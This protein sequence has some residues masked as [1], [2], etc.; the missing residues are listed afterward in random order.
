MQQPQDPAE[1][2]QVRELF[3]QAFDLPENDRQRYLDEVCG[4]NLDLLQKVKALLDQAGPA[5]KKLDEIAE[6]LIWPSLKSFKDTP[7][8]LDDWLGTGLDPN[9]NDSLTGKTISH[10]K[11][12]E[13]VGR[14]GMGVVYKAHDHM[15]ER[16]VALKFLPPAMGADSNAKERFIREAKVACEIDHPNIATVHEIGETEDGQMF[17]AMGYYQGESLKQRIDQGSINTKESI[18]LVRQLAA[19]LS[20]IHENKIIH[21]DIKPGN[22]IVT[23]DGTMK[24]LDF[25]LAKLSFESGYTQVGQ[26]IGTVAYMS[27]EQARAE[28]IDERTDI[29][30][31]GVVF[32]EMLTG[33][34]PFDGSDAPSTMHAILEKDPQLPPEFN[35]SIPRPV[36]EI[37]GLCL[38]K[39]PD[40]RYQSA[41]DLISDLDRVIEGERLPHR[42]G[43]K[44]WA[45]HSRKRKILIR[46]GIIGGAMALLFLSYMAFYMSSNDEARF[47]PVT[48][49]DFVE[50]LGSFADLA[51]GDYDND[52]WVDLVVTS[53]S[54]GKAAHLYHNDRKGGFERVRDSAIATEMGAGMSPSWADQDNDGDLD[55][56]ICTEKSKDLFFRNLGYGKFQK[57]LHGDWV[58]T[59]TDGNQVCWGDYDNDGQLDLYQANYGWTNPE[60]NSLYRNNGDGLMEAVF[61]ESNSLK[62][63]S[64]GCVF[65]DYDNDG[66]VD[67]FVGG[68]EKVLFR[69]ENGEMTHVPP[70]EGGIP[71]YTLDT[72]VAFVSGDYDN[73]GDLDVIYTTWNPDSSFL[74]YRNEGG[75]RF[76][77]V[78]HVTPSGGDVRSMGAYLGDY[79]NDGH[80]DLFITNR[81]G[82]NSLYRNLGNGSFELILDSPAVSEGRTSTGAAFSDYDNDGDLDLFVANGVWA[83][84]DESCE[85]YRNTG[86]SNSWISFSLVGTVSNKSAIG[87]KVRIRTPV[88]GRNL[89]QVREVSAS[90]NSND[91][92]AHFG[93]GDAK[94]I[95]FVRI[96]WPSGIVQDLTDVDVNQFLTVTEKVD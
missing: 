63:M 17:I 91:L 89:T 29:W 18:N 5:R 73:D 39:D 60:M 80:L 45:G 50:E 15:L 22:L 54:D 43:L 23:D 79:D 86:N 85:M 69:N 92:R 71:R 56:Y 42:G 52:G 34:R 12:L 84:F 93:L 11:I 62:G 96:E 1:A 8:I 78:P 67:L 6:E 3:E 90:S 20:K 53:Q 19:A 33:Q 66:D 59:K 27:P 75:V 55:L 65:S 64:H 72:D 70:E 58:N 38:A 24:L 46:S 4:D 88:N 35:D 74:L 14:G 48:K 25:G 7:S 44:T 31:L 28:K 41:S 83:D 57:E 10:F 95:D 81:L 40:K 68:Q 30:A 21:R 82:K 16:T 51:M 32:Y 36:Q 2:K 26:M 77:H 13:P 47:V 37:L 9:A 49:G 94:V 61:N 87:A 76:V